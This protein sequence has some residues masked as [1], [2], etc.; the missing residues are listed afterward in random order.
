MTSLNEEQVISNVEKFY[1]ISG[2]LVPLVGHVNTNYKLTSSDGS[3]YVVKISD[4]PGAV[5]LHSM[6]SK[7][8]EVL[9]KNYDNGPFPTVKE[10][11][12]GNFC[13]II[14]IDDEQ[15]SLRI[16]SWLGG[17]LFNE[18]E[19]TP[20]LLFDI[21][22]VLARMDLI[23]SRVNHINIKNRYYEWD[24]QYALFSK[25]LVHY[26]SDPSVR[27]S[28]S[29]FFQQFEF[30]VTPQFPNLR[31]SIIHSDAN[32]YNI[33]V[34]GSRVSGIIDFG[35]CVYTPVIN[36]LAIALSYA[37]MDVDDPI[38]MAKEMIRGYHGIYPL[39][40]NE[41][42][43]L[44]CL[45]GSRLAVC[46][47]RSA[48]LKNIDPDNEYLTISEEPALRLLQTWMLINPI[49]FTNALK[50][51]CGFGFNEI[52]IE[53]TLKERAVLVNPSLS[54]SYNSPIKM[55]SAAFQYM[56]ST[57]GST[58]LDCVNNICHVGHSH[59][60]VV[61]AA[62]RQMASLNTNT[63]YLYDQLNEYAGKLADKFPDPLNIVYLVNS[64]SEAG[65]LA[66]RIARTVT[67]S[68]NMIVVDH[69][70]HGNTISGIEVSPF[71]YEGKGGG[72]GADN[73]YKLTIPDCFRGEFKYDEPKAGEKY[74]KEINEVDKK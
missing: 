40:E 28:V 49:R 12:K 6:Q 73:I 67:G 43:L 2:E 26:I 52:S 72:G 14:H 34:H 30:F 62:G 64:G 4:D 17:T 35:D 15:L 23:L 63:R 25:H 21:G 3:K 32:D 13:E 74:A 1:G 16:L 27:R 48:Q 10:S 39:E 29:Y 18:A 50:I 44:Y 69:A 54:V 66:Q 19:H 45:I 11:L 68:I 61:E 46:L 42:E 55:A 71:K 38:T 56:Y 53:S 37:L 20:E 58:Y 5:D 51:T 41:V 60:K 70:Y 33:L 57:D 22:Q 36:E 59:P 31:K 8:L 65:D 24:L 9:H 7:I 47:T